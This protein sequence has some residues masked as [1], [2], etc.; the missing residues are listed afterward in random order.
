MGGAALQGERSG[1]V[2]VVGAGVLGAFHA[3]F[4]ARKGY[5]T[6]LFERNAF[7]NDA[8]TR[9]FGM[10]LR[11][12][13]ATGGEWAAYAEASARIYRELQQKLDLG[14]AV[15]GSLYL[16][17]TDLENCVLQEFADQFGQEYHCRYLAADEV[18]RRYPFARASYCQ[19]G[20]HF[21][22][23]LTLEPRRLLR[24]LIPHLVASGT[25]E[26]RPG[27][28]VV[29]VES[30]GEG[31]QVRDARGDV[32][33]ADHVFV[34]SG[35]DYRTLF[36]DAFMASGLRICKL[37]MMRTVPQERVLPHA[38]LSGLS[39]QRY[40]AF[41]ACASYRALEQQPQEEAL[42][43]YGI[44]LLFKQADDGTVIIG[45]SHEYRPLDEATPLEERT[46]PRINQAVLE[47]GQRMV[48]LPSW[49]IEGLW[50]GYY[51]IHPE[52]EILAEDIDGSVHIVTGIGGKGMSTGPGFAEAHIQR[53]LG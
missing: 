2:I 3:Y 46:D 35:S 17:S 23:D 6:L 53:V 50:N 52:R 1:D 11:T 37:Q 45:D 14:I 34:C 21:A 32:F 4:A 30:S 12:I 24:E 40:P 20:L 27:V 42:Q 5:R 7:P 15:S 38:L 10:A 49:E 25:L 39:I 28:T 44:H 31:C 18:C 16:A 8:S 41:K 33:R 26:Y 36:P 43:K 13:V 29:S 19:G 9:N 51:L 47:Y 48:T 22:E